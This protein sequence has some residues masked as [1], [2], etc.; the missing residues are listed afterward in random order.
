MGS[1]FTYYCLAEDLAR[2]Q[3]QVFVPTNSQLVAAEKKDGA[4]HI[5]PVEQFALEF[6]KMGKQTIFL[7]LLPPP[8]MQLEV[9]NG[10]WIDTSKSHLI[11][12][13]RCFND[14]KILRSARFW[15]E[16]RF[17]VGSELCSK[18]PEFLAWAESIYRKTKKQLQRH[19][20]NF[21]GHMYSEWFGPKAW[22]AVSNGKIEPV[23]N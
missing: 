14:G 7:Y 1:Q 2:I 13:G 18:P 22:S 6:E 11:E 19:E 16:S 23:P 5:V 8:K 3:E 20:I 17:F 21:S 10:P 12:V 4:H 15:Y 9:R